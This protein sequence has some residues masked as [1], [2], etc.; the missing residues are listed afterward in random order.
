MKNEV[1]KENKRFKLLI[2]G[3]PAVVEYA[4]Q[5]GKMYLNHSEVPSHLRGQEI[6]KILVEQTFEELTA[7]GY[8]AVAVCPFI[9]TIARQSQKW[10][11]LI[12]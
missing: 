6:E 9:K 2:N 7:R 1:T 3:D 11:A 8:Q 5:G 4:L 12:Q 10:N